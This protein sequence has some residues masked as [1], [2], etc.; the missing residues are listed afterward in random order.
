MKN[1]S[2]TKKKEFVTRFPLTFPSLCQYILFRGPLEQLW[3]LDIVY[4]FSQSP[5]IILVSDPSISVAIFFIRLR[6]F[7]VV[8]LLTSNSL[9][10]YEANSFFLKLHL[11]ALFA[12]LETFLRKYST[13]YNLQIPYSSHIQSVSLISFF[14]FNRHI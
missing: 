5:F 1:I 13:D 7:L 3:Q 8:L 12:P 6:G 9:S 4:F 14:F 11:P 10:W 2:S